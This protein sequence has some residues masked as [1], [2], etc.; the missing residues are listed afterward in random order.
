MF[1]TAL[2]ISAQAVPQDMMALDSATK[3]LLQCQF[4]IARAAN[5]EH[6]TVEAF[7]RRL[8]SSCLAE[9]QALERVSAA[10]SARRGEANATSQ[11]RDMTAEGRRTMVE[12]YRQVLEMQR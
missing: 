2:L 9:E 4:A 12:T 5:G 3:A 6:L 1:A 11:A 10:F 8:D 7:E